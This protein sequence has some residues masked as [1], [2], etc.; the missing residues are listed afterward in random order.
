M[1][2]EW[3]HDIKAGLNKYRAEVLPL[4][5]E[6]SYGSASMELLNVINSLEDGYKKMRRN[7]IKIFTQGLLARFMV[8]HDTCFKDHDSE[9]IKNYVRSDLELIEER[10]KFVDFGVDAAL[11]AEA[12]QN[13]EQYQQGL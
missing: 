10:I 1:K 8:L 11:K 2:N 12:E 9:N 5:A 13:G 7:S 3:A 6:G 4:I